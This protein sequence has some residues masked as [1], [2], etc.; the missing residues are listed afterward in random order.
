MDDDL[1]EVGRSVARGRRG[2]PDYR[3]EALEGL[4]R[5]PAAVLGQPALIVD[6]GPETRAQYAAEPLPLVQAG[7][8]REMGENLLNVPLRT[9]TAMLPLLRA[10]PR[11][12]EASQSRCAVGR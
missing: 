7:C 4:G 11:A 3:A 12:M 8:G 9:E 10:E 5:C 2:T 1:A 6:I